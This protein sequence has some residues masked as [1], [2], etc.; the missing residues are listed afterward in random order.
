MVANPL[1]GDAFDPRIFEITAT[2]IAEAII[3]ANSQLT[4][5]RLGVGT[6]D[7]HNASNNRSFE[8]FLHNPDVPTDPTAVLII[9]SSKRFS[10]HGIK[11]GTRVRTLRRRLRGERSVRVGRNVWYLARSGGVRQLF[12]TRGGRVLEVGIG[13]R[14][15]SPTR[16]AAKRYLR[17]WQLG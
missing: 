13:D 12:K 7:V 8:S 16:R 6:S 2:G 11:S 10:V 5:A 9:T 15:L 1:L 14:R 3:E 4:P 17:A